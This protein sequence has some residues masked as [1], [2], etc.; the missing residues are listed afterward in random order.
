MLADDDPRLLVHLD[1]EQ[2]QGLVLLILAP[3]GQDTPELLPVDGVIGLLEVNEGR[4]VPPLLALPRVDLGQE[5]GN[6]SGGGG[7]LLEARLVDPRLKQVRGESSYLGHD[8][9]L[10][11][12]GHVG[13]HHDRPDVLEL[14]LVLALILR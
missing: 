14:R 11:Y 9:L 2:G 10:Q 1:D 8:S 7:V 3:A 12:L 5:P 6:M 4:V 13:P